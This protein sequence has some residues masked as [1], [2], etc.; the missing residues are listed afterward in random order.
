MF[1][2]YIRL[3]CITVIILTV[4]AIVC[5]PQKAFDSS[6][7]GL[8]VWWNVVFPATLPFLMLTHLFTAL[9]V[10]SALGVLLEPLTKKWFLL[11]G[12]AGWTIAVGMIAGFPTGAHAALQL[13]E[14]EHMTKRQTL[15][16]CSITS[17][18]NPMTILLVIGVA[19]L[20][21]PFAGYFLLIIHWVCGWMTMA[22]I[23][24]VLVYCKYIDVACPPYSFKTDQ[25]IRCRLWKKAASAAYHARLNDGRPLGKLLGNAVTQSVDALMMTGC[26]IIICAVFIRMVTMY[27]HSGYYRTL[28]SSFVEV[29]L[30]TF[31]ISELSISI[32][33]TI[34]F[35]SA[36]LGWGGICAYLQISAF[37][38]PVCMF[39]LLFMGT[40]FLHATLSFVFSTLLW[41]PFCQMLS[42]NAFHIPSISEQWV[43]EDSIK[44]WLSFSYIFPKTALSF[45]ILLTFLIALSYVTHKWSRS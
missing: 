42:V 23:M 31:A 41:T 16:V 36:A 1:K 11:P 18:V 38:K 15:A 44:K 30:G 33:G 8:S 19:F 32:Q 29:H 40:K 28:W 5:S 24:R 34:S 20:K 45:V 9:G 17:F 14:R 35:L 22:I 13:Y 3:V 43:G 27:L 2:K 12:S 7:Q 6:V 25:K 26:Y 21:Q 10:T 37:I 39:P 4:F